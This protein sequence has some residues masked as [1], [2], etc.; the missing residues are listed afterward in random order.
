MVHAGRIIFEEHHPVSRAAAVGNPGETL[1]CY[2]G[3]V[4]VRHVRP[5][6]TAAAL[7]QKFPSIELKK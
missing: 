6:V 3:D 4:N 1:Y 2:V 7:F 5:A